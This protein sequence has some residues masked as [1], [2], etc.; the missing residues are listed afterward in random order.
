LTNTAAREV[1]GRRTADAAE[2]D[3]KNGR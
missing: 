2:T 1:T 3:D